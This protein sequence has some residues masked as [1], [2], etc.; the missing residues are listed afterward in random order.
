[1][2]S[3]PISGGLSATA[4]A[5]LAPFSSLAKYAQELPRLIASGS[6]LSRWP[7][8]TLNDPAARSLDVGLSLEKPVELGSG[9]PELTLGAE[10]AVHF[11]VLTGKM[12]SPDVYGENP[13][14]PEGQC[15]VRLG[16]TAT[17]TS[18]VSG[19]S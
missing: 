18:G 10:A 2:P 19:T 8:L 13:T 3:I 17:A 5:E 14:I 4:N 6:D 1:M 11:E 16:V 12:F 7:V 15:A 9:A